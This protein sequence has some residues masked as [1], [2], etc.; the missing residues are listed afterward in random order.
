MSNHAR[1]KAN[2]DEVALTCLAI[3]PIINVIWIRSDWKNVFGG[4]IEGSFVLV[5]VLVL[6]FLVGL[7]TK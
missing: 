3:P 7:G 4:D 1:L 2:D 6:F 5:C